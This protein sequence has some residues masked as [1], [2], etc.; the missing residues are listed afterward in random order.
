[1]RAMKNSGVE[2]IGEIPESWG[3][4]KLK[5]FVDCY[6][7]KRVPIDSA[8]RQT[9]SYPYWG[10]GS[11]TDY[12]NDYIFD[13]ELVL[14]GEDGAPFFDYT[15]PVAFL[16]NEKIW[17]NNH[18]HVLKVHENMNSNYIVRFLNSVDFKS[19]INGSILNKLT[20]SNM[21]EIAMLYPSL[22]EQHRIADYLDDKCSKIDNIIEK[23]QQV[24]EKLK[25]YKL[26]VITEAVTK[27]LD[28]DAEMKDSGVECIGRIP[29]KW[30]T[31][32][33]GRVSTIRS[34]ITLGR[35]IPENTKLIE[36]PY[37][38]VANVQNG[39]VDTSN[40]TVLEVTED[41]DKKYRL[42]N[43]DVLMT[44]GGDR[45]KLGRGCVW[46]ASI[47]PCLHQNHIFAL[48]TNLKFLNQFYF[49]YVT[50]SKVGRVYFD[51]TAIKTTNLA[52]TSASK[53]SAFRIPLPPIREQQMIVE[54]LDKKCLAIET[55]ISKKQAILDKLA[56][57]KKSLVYEVV[58]GK[59]EV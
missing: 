30:E 47:E 36:R 16:V 21:N 13:E 18:I 38:R 12:V 41:E 7:G 11:I 22:S 59:K 25:E 29:E 14:L 46:N 32:K 51:M 57:Y 48:N 50:A 20:Q 40:V 43:G 1:M 23:Q 37:L 3:V 33:L 10:A 53:V 19:Y 34:G 56:E 42:R 17:V 39:F 5:Y 55:T 28:P 54:Y 26:S 6:D 58:T 45:D 35:K 2:W 8:K 44:E 31:T 4:S 9:G 27:G 52:C 15:R 24:I 49:S